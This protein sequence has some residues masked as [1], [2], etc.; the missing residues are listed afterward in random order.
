MQRNSGLQTASESDWADWIRKISQ[1]DEASLCALYDAAVNRL[2]SVALHIT[3]VPSSAEEVVQS[4]FFQV[5]RSA[6]SFDVGR[7]SPLAWLLVMCRSQAL[8]KLR[9]ADTAVP[10]ADVESLIE[11]SKNEDEDPQSLLLAI[12]QKTTLHLAL[13]TLCS[14]DRQLLALAFFRGFSY[15]EI[16]EQMMMPLGTVKSCIRQ[17]L[18]SLRRKLNPLNLRG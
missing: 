17:A 6:A 13:Q 3:R 16:A 10:Y 11:E 9:S 14:R 7:G 15:S 12:E 18:Q 1:G 4:V 8:A 5:W 2:Y